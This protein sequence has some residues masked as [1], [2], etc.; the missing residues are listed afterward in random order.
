[1]GTIQAVATSILPP[2]PARQ[3]P[4]CALVVFGASGDLTH[5]KL[6]PAL[7]NLMMGGSL[8][9]AFAVVGVARRPWSDEEFRAEMNGAVERFSSGVPVQPDGWQRFAHHLDYVAGEFDD[10]ATYQRLA[11]RLTELDQKHG[12]AGNRLFYL[13]TPPDAFDNILTHL[14]QAKMIA[15]PGAPSWTRVIIEK[16]FGT[17]LA[18]AQELNQLVARVLAES[19]TFR[20]DHYLGKETVQNILVFRFANLIFEPIWNRRYVDHVEI[21]AAETVGV[22]RRGKFYDE[23]GVL[24]DVVQNHLLELLCLVAME[25]P[26]TGEADDIRGEKLKVLNGLR[27]LWS[28]TIPRNVVLGQYRGYRQ[29][30]DVNPQSVTPTYAALRVFVDN[31]RWKGVPFYLRT[32]KKLPQRVTEITL[33]M[34]EVPL[35]LFNREDRIDRIAPNVIKLRIQ[36]DEGIQI[37]FGSKVPGHDLSVG[38]VM[39]DM[40]YREA[41]GGQ[42]PEAYERLLLDAMRGDATLFSR[43]DAVEASW[44]WITPILEHFAANP[45]TDLPNYDAGSWGPEAAAE[46]MHRDRRTWTEP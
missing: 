16:P 43:R 1:M 23:I 37:Q 32:G 12:L 30:P 25:P 9:E 39:M 35:S 38:S 19:Q 20:I 44:A 33:H 31:W 6:I 8:S 41:F 21:T 24:R 36:P 15:P 34:Q 42:P 2:R 14:E 27:D 45:P 40:N 28:D 22:E 11:Q 26:V 10:P 3:A 29:E 46:L 5:R 7:Y 13:A 17:D 18:T 4:P